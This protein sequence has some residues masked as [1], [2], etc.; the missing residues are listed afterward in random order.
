MMQDKIKFAALGLIISAALT[1]AAGEVL[2]AAPAEENTNSQPVQKQRMDSPQGIGAPNGFA[3]RLGGP[4]GFGTNYTT[5]SQ[6]KIL[7]DETYVT[8]R[9]EFTR[10]L[11]ADKF[12]FRDNTGVITVDLD[13]DYN[14]AFIRPN[15][16]VEIEGEVD[17]EW[18]GVE[19][20]AYTGRRLQ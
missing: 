7:W 8:L 9:G 20:N 17:R 11:S 2:A 16:M 10:R 18:F 19:I 5:V 13:D 12:E 4:Q 6:A 15:V 14:W 1:F 3:E